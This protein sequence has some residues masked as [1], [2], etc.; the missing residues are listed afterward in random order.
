MDRR[1]FVSGLAL[2]ALG[3]IPFPAA[4][5]ATAGAPP[6]MLAQVYRPGI[7][8][9]ADCWVSEKYDGVRGYWDGRQLLTRGGESIATPAWFTA[10]WPAVPMDGELWA[11]REH[12]TQAVSTVRQ[13]T[14]DEAAW[15]A[16]RFMVFDLPAHGGPFTER[17]AAYQ[18]LLAQL[19]LAWVQP[20]AQRQIGSHAALQAL[21]QQTVQAG[22][23]GLVLHRGASPYRAARS[24]DLLK[25]KPYD[26][27]EAQ[28]IAH[29]PGRGQH[30]GRLGALL[31]QLPDG[32]QLRLGTGFT[33]AQREHPPAIGTWVTYRHRGLT[34]RG[35]PRFASFLRVREG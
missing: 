26:D 10:G 18:Q 19:A 20:V 28:V 17:L 7:T 22:G 29:L 4:L 32:Q 30:A 6:L 11:G 34:D 3:T 16:M 9:L 15:R 14:P 8:P 13:Q 25:F 2:A 5:A 12:F 35:L 31:V 24:E 33:Q 23:E 21:L 27:A 1:G